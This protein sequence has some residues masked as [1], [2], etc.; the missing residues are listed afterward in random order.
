MKR[1]CHCGAVTKRVPCDKCKIPRRHEKKKEWYDH[2]WRVLSERVRADNPLGHDCN[3]NGITSPSEEVH[4]IKP[5]S[6]YPELR[7]RLDNIV[8]LCKECHATRHRNIRAGQPQWV[9][10]ES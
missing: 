5:V 7:L 9:R 6:E 4:H 3:W 8:A 2:K 10:P 1:L